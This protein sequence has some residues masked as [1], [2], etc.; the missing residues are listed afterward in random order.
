MIGEKVHN[1]LVEL[2]KLNQPSTALV[3]IVQS[4][5]LNNYTMD[6]QP[7]DGGA[8]YHGV[9]LK[10]A[11]D[12][13]QTGMLIVPK[14]NASV[15]MIQLNNN[16]HALAMISTSEID[17]I[18]ITTGNMNF[19]INQ[20]A[21]ELNG[22]TYGGVLKHADVK[23][24]LDTFNSNFTILKSAIQAGFSALAPLDGSASINAFNAFSNALQTAQTNNLENPKVQHG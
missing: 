10:T 6:V 11:I 12:G 19:V 7:F 13:N 9:R 24:A 5:N 15:V 14:V 21:I 23:A 16:A 17:K 22:T 18:F 4:V 20:S 1:A 2:I 3:G 8:L